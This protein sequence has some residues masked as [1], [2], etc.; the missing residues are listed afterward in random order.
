MYKKLSASGG[1]APPDPPPGALTRSPWSAPL[2]NP[3]SATGSKLWCSN[4]AIKNA[5]WG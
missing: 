4:L 2:A 1:F 3:G 5:F